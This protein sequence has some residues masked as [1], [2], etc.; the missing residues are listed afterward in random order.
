MVRN[1]VLD[2]SFISGLLNEND[3]HHTAAAKQYSEMKDLKNIKL[4]VSAVTIL[5]LS[6]IKWALPFEI[7]KILEFLQKNLA[8]E[9]VY[10]DQDQLD[11][12]EQLVG[13]DTN[14]KPN[15]FCIAITGLRKAA[16]LLTFD[17][18][19]KAEYTKLKKKYLLL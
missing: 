15:D 19:L 6:R 10:L 3:D 17:T 8:H 7:T 4:I 14:L 9:V 13:M 2:T 5:E 1:I 11:Y 18:K 16:E 12:I